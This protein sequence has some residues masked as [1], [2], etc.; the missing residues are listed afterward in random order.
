MP[1]DD[2]DDA[3]ERPELQPS[4][5]S[6]PYDSE[7][8][9]NNPEFQRLIAE[10]EDDS[11]YGMPR[12]EEDHRCVTTTRALLIRTLALLCACSLSVGSH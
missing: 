3:L 4:A 8:L 1:Y 11:V 7:L 2:V 6:S 10:R 5:M 12:V 9:E